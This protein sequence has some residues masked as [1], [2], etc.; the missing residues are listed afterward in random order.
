MADTRHRGTAGALLLLAGFALFLLREPLVGDKTFAVN[1]MRL[2]APWNTPAELT[3]QNNAGTDGTL[4]F[5]PRRLF[6]RSELL[7]GRVP[8]WNPWNFAGLPFQ[9]DP[10]TALFYP[11]NLLYL[12]IEPHEAMA[13]L[14]WLQLF[15]AGA[16]TYAFCRELN[17]RPGAALIGGLIFQ[18][19][20]FL[21]THL[22]NPT[23]ADSGIW[24]PASLL[25]IE[26]IH[27]GHRPHAAAA[28]LAATVALSILGGFPP[29]AVYAFYAVV[30]YGLAK[31]AAEWRETRDLRPGLLIGAALALGL[32]L[33]AVQLLPVLELSQISGR[34]AV[35]YEDFRAIFLPFEALVSYLVPGFFGD[36]LH[37]WLGAFCSA[38]RDQAYESYFWRNSYLENS[39]YAGIFPLVLAAAAIARRRRPKLALFFL[40]MSLISL[41]LTLGWPTFRL[42]H[43][44][45]P[46]FKFSRICRITYLY[47][48]G[49]A[50]LGAL[51]VDA[52][53]ARRP[54][55]TGRWIA[56]Q[57]GLAAVLL[58]LVVPP[59]RE[60]DER[61]EALGDRGRS[62]RHSADWIENRSGAWDLARRRIYWNY[63]TWLR[64]IIVL[65]GLSTGAVVILV[66]YGQRIIGPRAFVA[67]SAYL[68]SVDIAME[69]DR[70]F[71]FQD[72][73][74]PSHMPESIGFLSNAAEGSR[75]TRY[76]D[77][78]EVLPPNSGQVFG[79]ADIQGS[80]ALLPR[81]YG[82]LVAQVHPDMFVGFK[83]VIAIP[84]AEALASPILD[85][86]GVR[87]AM[88]SRFIPTGDLASSGSPLLHWRLVYNKEIKIYENRRALP[89][90]F[91]VEE[92][93][94]A[95]SGGLTLRLLDD[96][97][98]H[99]RRIVVV[100]PDAPTLEQVSA[101]SAELAAGPSWVE[102]DHRPGR[103]A[104]DARVDKPAWLVV[105]EAAAPGWRARLDGE[106]AQAWRANHIF[107]AIPLAPGEHEVEL[108]Y[109]P[110]AI[111][112]GA[113][114]TFVAAI[115]AIGQWLG[116]IHPRALP[117]RSSA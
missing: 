13:W 70:Y 2:F 89:R 116:L 45:L 98:F 58:T 18:S 103:I 11:P 5:Y 34:K 66:L 36:P 114:T 28:C 104:I 85:L 47:G 25:F 1:D 56:L 57:V 12:L 59:S 22:V 16:F 81:P 93:L 41:T 102:I 53:L 113:W 84:D 43:T 72:E 83:K 29:I 7:A 75:I 96:P 8:L 115:L 74:Y 106:R 19:N 78:R 60:I 50:V 65:L 39:G 117:E 100:P 21:L 71:T 82:E 86:L 6:A 48:T 79:I 80:N 24:L 17:L 52:L 51:G 54:G 63:D 37:S 95:P 42:A 68:I 62:V 26:R 91:L 111:R 46:G 107:Q 77:F 9:A 23:N 32:V 90:A 35:A 94:H 67:C 88:S 33:A 76:G 92:A 108:E 112:V 38:T 3:E 73:F 61:L 105:T 109:R 44:F 87:Y 15:L 31:M 27:R 20:P 55:R 64:G 10:H 99:P 40:G 4:T 30:A 14:A 49:V 110:Q 69:A 101:S 97:E